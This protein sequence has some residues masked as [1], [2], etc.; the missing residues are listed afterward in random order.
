MITQYVAQ[1][2]SGAGGLLLLIF[3]YREFIEF[4]CRVVKTLK[5]PFLW[6]AAL[7]KMPFRLND[8]AIAARVRMDIMESILNDLAKFVKKELT[9]NGGSSTLDAIR[10]IENRIIE[11]EYA[12]NALVLDSENG[13]FRCS[14]DG[15]NKWVNRTYARYLGCGTSELLGFGWKRFIKTD[16][17]RRYNNVWQDA[18]KDGCE[19]EDVVEFT[20]V[21]HKSIKL[22]IA[23]C[24]II[25]DKGKILSYVGTV[26]AL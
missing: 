23:T 18:F 3:K 17:L 19:F 22:Q 1:I 9:Y 11:Q 10:R 21:D 13:F 24:P 12:Q 26:V 25:D 7:A 6:I 8:E 16:E 4:L 14:L 5:R 2:V 20:D 15:Q